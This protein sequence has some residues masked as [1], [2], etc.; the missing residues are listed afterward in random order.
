V[1]RPKG[2]FARGR[3]KGRRRQRAYL[4]SCEPLRELWTLGGNHWAVRANAPAVRRAIW[5]EKERTA[6]L[7]DLEH[8]D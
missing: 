6:I 3:T 5:I 7:W 2:K 4:R 1:G 8:D